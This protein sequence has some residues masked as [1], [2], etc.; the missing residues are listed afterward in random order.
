MNLISA[1]P[2][3]R[4]VDHDRGL[5]AHQP[6]FR[7]VVPRFSRL[8]H[9]RSPLVRA[10]GLPPLGPGGVQVGTPECTPY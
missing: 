1:R 9:S 2:K 3:D 7:E 6:R 8:V 10:W 5:R 4:R